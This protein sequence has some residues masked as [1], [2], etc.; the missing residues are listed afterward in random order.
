MH[1]Y[2]W[3]GSEIYQIWTVNEANQSDWPKETQKKCPVKV[4]QTAMRAWPGTL[5]LSL[6]LYV[7]THTILFF[8][9]I[10]TWLVSVLSIFVGIHFC[11][12][13]GPRPLSLTAGLVPRIWC[14]H[15]HYT[16]SISSWKP[17]P[18]SKPL[19]AMAAQDHSQSPLRSRFSF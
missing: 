13:K 7:S 15:C 9:I 18:C 12:A 1:A 2:A 14:F 19:Q 17:K 11:K 6:P 10:N 8:L 3:E 4:I 5:L 16:A